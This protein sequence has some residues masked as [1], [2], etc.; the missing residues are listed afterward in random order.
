LGRYAQPIRET[1]AQRWGIYKYPP[2][3]EG[4]VFYSHSILSLSILVHSSD[5]SIGA[6]AGTTSPQVV[7][8]AQHQ[9][10]FIMLNIHWP[11]NLSNQ[12]VGPK[13]KIKL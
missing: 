9:Q 8:A 10:G 7:I 13:I 1:L 11:N 12:Q 3:L 2:L 4:Q 6:P 5:L